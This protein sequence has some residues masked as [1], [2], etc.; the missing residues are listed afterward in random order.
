MRTDI[1]KG[2]IQSLKNSTVAITCEV[3][4]FEIYKKIPLFE[5]IFSFL[6]SYNFTFIGF[7]NLNHRSTKN[8]Y[9]LNSPVRERL[10]QAD[11][12]FLK[13]P[14]E[15]KITNRKIKIIIFYLLINGYIDYLIEILKTKKLDGS[16]EIIKII[17]K[18][19]CN[20][21]FISFLSKIN[22]NKSQMID[23]L[24]KVDIFRDYSNINDL[25]T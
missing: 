5:E 17:D 19:Y 7:Q 4:F 2:A 12:I 14:I 10:M 18:V 13:D 25:E 22:K 24:K 20:K 3:T 8:F 16:N 1:L 9:K 15:R 6:K 21:N 11:A 23:I